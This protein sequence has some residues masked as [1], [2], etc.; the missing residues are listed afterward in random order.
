MRPLLVFLF[1]AT[2]AHAA[3][4]PAKVE[5]IRGLIRDRKVAQAEAAVNTLVTG[6]PREPEAHAL[7]ASLRAAKE[8]PDGAVKAAE[9][10]VELAPN[11]SDYHRQLGDAYGFAAQKA[12]I[13]SKMGLGKKCRLAYEKAVELDP[14][15]LNARSSL[16]LFYQMAPGI[17][18]GG[19]DKA[20]A[21]AAEIKKRDASR[22]F[23]AY[24][25]LYTGEKKFP[26]AWA[27]VDAAL[28]AAPDDYQA[29]F[30]AGR[31]A[32]LSGEQI[33]RGME[34][35]KKCL[36][37]TPPIGA[38]GHDAVHWRLGN[39]WEKKGDKAAARA[40]YQAALK[41]NPNFPQAIDALKKLN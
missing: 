35:L 30:Q 38:P 13:L 41:V 7:L 18:G 17:A 32:V 11:H 14:A 1:T 12:G 31:T 2:L 19:M 15:N 24:V 16:V 3:I 33:D 6:H 37:L 29:L 9:K 27:E 25:L 22:G 21:Q 39:L 10:A 26:E 40:A 20:Y 23:I 28:K 34:T 4:A 5:E 36:T 8:D